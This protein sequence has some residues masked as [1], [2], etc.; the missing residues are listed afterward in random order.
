[1]DPDDFVSVAKY[2][3]L[4]RTSLAFGRRTVFVMHS[5]PEAIASLLLTTWPGLSCRISDRV[6]I[7]SHWPV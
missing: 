2:V 6:L 4:V 1:M 5:Y 7:V 3:H